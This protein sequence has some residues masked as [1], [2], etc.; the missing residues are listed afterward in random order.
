[1]AIFPS[2]VSFVKDMSHM[3]QGANAFTR[4]LSS[5]RTSSL[6]RMYRLLYDSHANPDLSNWDVSKVTNMERVFDEAYSFNQDI[7]SWDVSSVTN[8]HYMFSH[9]RKFNGEL[10]DWDTSN[11]RNMYYMF[12]YAY[13]FNQ[14]LDKWDTSRVTDMHYMF[15]YAH[16][17]NGTVGTWD[18]SQVTTMRFMFRYCYDFNQNISKWDTSK[19]ADMDYMFYDA[20][21]FAQDLSDWTGSAVANYQSEMFRGATAFQSKYWCPDVNRGPPMWCQCKN[22]CP[23]SS[24]PSSSP[25][26]L[27]PITNE[28]IKDAIKACLYSNAGAHFVDGLC[29]LSEYGAM[30]DWDVSKVTDMERLFEGYSNFNA[31]ITAWDVSSVTDMSYMFQSANAFTQDLSDWDTSSLTTT[32]RMRIRRFHTGTY[33]KSQIWI[34]CLITRILLTRILAR[35]T[36]PPLQRITCS[37]TAQDVNQDL[38]GWDTS[39]VQNMEGMFQSE[40]LQRRH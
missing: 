34:V 23:I 38:N 12:H 37:I 33:R 25:S 35:G 19:V 3:F 4:D 2:D 22:D 24:T 36:F 39:R 20:R 10:N 30:P 29:D 26:V 32:L 6:T 17:F 8:M 11:V 1:M 16:D 31:D 5:W 13:D 21:S 40:C 9:A 14:D 27:T 15:E 7:S 28:N 18:V